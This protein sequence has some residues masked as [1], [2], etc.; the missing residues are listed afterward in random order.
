MKYGMRFL[1]LST[2]DE[3]IQEMKRLG[4]DPSGI[5]LM[6]PKGLTRP[7]RLSGVPCK[8]ANLLKQELL[9]RGGDCAVAHGTLTHSVETTD[10][11]MIATERQYRKLIR[12]LKIQKIFGLPELAHEIHQ[13]LRNLNRKQFTLSIGEDHLDLDERTHI[14]GVLNMTPDS[15]SDGGTYFDPEKAYRHALQLVEEGADIIDVGGESTRPGSKEISEQEETERILP[16]IERL[17]KVKGNDWLRS[18]AP[19]DAGGCTHFL[20]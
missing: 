18:Q 3:L 17:S 19:P 4:A 1:S 6:F 9:S 16:V 13:I 2:R 10:V 12:K 5:A 15:F 8:I 14:M 11:L 20:N 7:I